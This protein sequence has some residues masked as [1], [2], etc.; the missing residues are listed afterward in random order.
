[1]HLC[2]M[3]GLEALP[4]IFMHVCNL[5]LIEAD[6]LSYIPYYNQSAVNENRWDGILAVA[7]MMP[8]LR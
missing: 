5:Y 6:A 7:L 8:V 2:G 3:R 4:P 1:M